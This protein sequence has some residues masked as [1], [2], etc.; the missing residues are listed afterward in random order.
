DDDAD[1]VDP[2]RRGDLRFFTGGGAW[3]VLGALVVAIAAFPALAAWN[4]L[5][6][7][8]LEPLAANLGRLWGD[9]AYGLRSA[10]LDAVGPAAPFAA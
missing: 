2:A 6:G 4:V 3:L 9:A 7:G 1:S 5:G 8:G 10:G